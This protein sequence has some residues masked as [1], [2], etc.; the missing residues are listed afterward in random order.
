MENP[1]TA[2][3]YWLHCM[4]SSTIPACRPADLATRREIAASSLEQF[5]AP[6]VTSSHQIHKCVTRVNR[7][8]N[9][10]VTTGAK[11]L[12]CV[13]SRRCMQCNA[14]GDSSNCET[15]YAL[16]DA[17]QCCCVEWWFNLRAK[18]ALIFCLLTSDGM[19]M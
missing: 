10:C 5:L 3:H 2:S 18:I 9:F 14:S 11:S 19:V 13:M 6:A 7:V 12:Q 8:F 15:R 16:T 17:V 1:M 4:K